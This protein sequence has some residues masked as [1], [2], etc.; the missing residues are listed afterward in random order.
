MCTR[1]A[2]PP[3]DASQGRR[4][5][6]VPCRTGVAAALMAALGAIAVT[7]AQKPPAT[8]SGK[9]AAPSGNTPASAPASV[10]VS[11]DYVIG[12][13]DV[14]T[15]VVWKEQ[16]VSGDF[17]VRPD[18]KISMPLMNDIVAAGLTPDQ[19]RARVTEAAAKFIEE[20]TVTVVVKEINSRKVFVVG[21]VAKPGPYPLLVPTRVVQVVALAGGLLEYAKEENISI[22]RTENGR[23]VSYRFNYKDFTRGRNLEQNIE[24]KP[25]DTVIVPD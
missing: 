8:T 2:T 23:Q 16:D 1:S 19:L 10:Q 12:P 21:Q 22:V 13:D 5:S 11:P 6:A 25:G 18:G 17:T 15:V 9:P 4:V 20:P 7:Q 24:L 14:I 3:C